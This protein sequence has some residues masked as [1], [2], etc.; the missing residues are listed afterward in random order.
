MIRSIRR[1]LFIS[2]FVSITVASSITAI[3]NYL[4]DKKIIQPYLDTELVR[5]YTVIEKLHQL[6]VIDQPTRN[7]ITNYL[8]TTNTP[9][10]MFQIW[11]KEGK[12]LF[13]SANSEFL[14]LKESPIGFSDRLIHR[15]DWRLYANQDQL[16]QTKIIVG[17]IYNIRNKLTDIITRNNGYILLVTFPIFEQPFLANVLPL[18]LTHLL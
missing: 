6:S 18:L 16:T 17:E 13:H 4:L 10:F 11:S 7:K 14:S 12:L 2:L 9:H 15:D 5:I 8:K 1:F 3:G